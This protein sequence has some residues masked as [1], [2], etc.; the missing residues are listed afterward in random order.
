[1]IGNSWYY[2]LQVRNISVKRSYREISKGKVLVR[3]SVTMAT[4]VRKK[5]IRVAIHLSEEV[6]LLLLYVFNGKSK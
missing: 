5:P 4:N 6:V 1:M 3:S 2:V